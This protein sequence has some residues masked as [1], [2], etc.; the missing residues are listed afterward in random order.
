MFVL[1]FNENPAG[2]V[3]TTLLLAA[4]R[5]VAPETRTSGELLSRGLAFRPATTT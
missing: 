5:S 1:S 2:I 3:N 4:S